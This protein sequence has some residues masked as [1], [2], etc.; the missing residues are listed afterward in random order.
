MALAELLDS[1]RRKR[2]T[3]DDIINAVAQHYA[4]DERVL[5]GRGRSRNIVVPRQVAMYLLRE[6]TESSLVE[7]GNALGGRDHTTVMHGCEKIAEEINTD[8]R[9]RGEVLEI[10]ETLYGGRK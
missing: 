10:R 4:I 3:V 1:T 5:K 9:L 2:I 6:E 7:I 8:S